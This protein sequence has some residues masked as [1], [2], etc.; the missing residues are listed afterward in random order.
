MGRLR[1]PNVISTHLR[2]SS[3]NSTTAPAGTTGAHIRPLVVSPARA[4]SM[5][6]LLE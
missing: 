2:R 5:A 4:S 3:D 6:M 1:S